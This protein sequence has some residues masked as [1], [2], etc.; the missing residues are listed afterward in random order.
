MTSFFVAI[1][2]DLIRFRLGNV[3]A[4]MAIKDISKIF[5][6]KPWLNIS[7]IRWIIAGTWA[8]T[9]FASLE[10]RHAVSWFSSVV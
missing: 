10:T 7:R 6:V 9:Y 1:V 5:H 2:Q 4:H 3:P 8:R